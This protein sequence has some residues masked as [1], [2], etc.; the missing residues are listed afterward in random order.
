M[1][2][3]FSV[4]AKAYA[5]SFALESHLLSGPFIPIRKLHGLFE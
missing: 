2:R 4:Q 3:K 5:F 1:P